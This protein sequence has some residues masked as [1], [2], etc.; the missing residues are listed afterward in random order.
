MTTEK[1][2]D[3]MQHKPTDTVVLEV[4]ELQKRYGQDGPVAVQ[5]ISLNVRDR[6]FVS[7]VGPS[8]CGKTTLLKSI[9]NLLKPSSGQVILH[10]NRVTAPPPEM[11][12]VFQDYSRSLFPWLTVMGNVMFPLKNEK[13]LG[14]AEK[15]QRA[16]ETIEAVGL[17]KFAD[18][19]PWQLSGGCS[20]ASP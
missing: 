11:V 5:S 4:D 3:E 18:H 1:F 14:K 7:I 16:E 17:T 10:G 9:C 6:E 2:V 8:G 12:L 13:S 19:Y 20:N 15:K